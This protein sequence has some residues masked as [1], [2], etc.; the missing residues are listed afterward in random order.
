LYP[1]RATLPC[2]NEPSRASCR[3]TYIRLT[4]PHPYP[5]EQNNNNHG[6]GQQDV[7][8]QNNNNH[9]DEQKGKKGKDRGRNRNRNNAHPYNQYGPGKGKGG[10][11]NDPVPYH[12]QLQQPYAPTSTQQHVQQVP[13]APEFDWAR[14]RKTVKKAV[15]SEL[16]EFHGTLQ[17]AADL[18]NGRKQGGGATSSAKPNTRRRSIS[19][20][21][22]SSSEDKPTKKR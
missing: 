11:Y 10:F 17:L 20:S 21:S 9:Q 6:E 14:M 4:Y 19:S 1:A 7:H 2:S 5:P 15:R 22:D 13:A 3:E 8:E 12:Y 18:Q 16:R